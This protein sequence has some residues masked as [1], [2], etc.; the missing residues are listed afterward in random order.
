[1]IDG[2]DTRNPKQIFGHVDL[3]KVEINCDMLHTGIKIRVRAYIYKW[4][5]HFNERLLELR[6]VECGV[7]V[8]ETVPM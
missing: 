7:Y 2:G 6:I 3:N 5:Q 4:P 8:G 1:M